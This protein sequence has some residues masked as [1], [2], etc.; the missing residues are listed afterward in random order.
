MCV[1]RQR[2]D[3]RIPLLRLFNNRQ[4]AQPASPP[5][6]L[7]D[8]EGRNVNPGSDPTPES[9]DSSPRSD[10]EAG[11]DRS[12]RP[13]IRRKL[14]DSTSMEVNNFKAKNILFCDYS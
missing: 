12:E 8:L 7:N 13:I 11:P 14:I 3:E 4:R 10:V 9:I 2:S 5:I 6:P 1:Q